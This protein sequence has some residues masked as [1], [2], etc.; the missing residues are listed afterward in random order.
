MEE[1]RIIPFENLG[2]FVKE[3]K[4]KGEKI[5]LT[6]GVWDLLHVGHIRYMQAAKDKGTVLIVGIDSDRLTKARKGE[7]RPIVP[8]GERIE[9]LQAL[10]CVDYVV[11]KDNLEDNVELVRIIMPDILIISETTEDGKLEEI[12]NDRGHYCGEIVCLKPQAQ[13]STTNRIREI[14]K[15]GSVDAFQ[16]LMK[17]LEQVFDK[18][19]IKFRGDGKE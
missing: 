17:D 2:K 8:E 18:H 5:V 13:T 3:L 1:T 12:K 19:G 14:V 7:H 15:T 16:V 10:R 11:L 4:D 9:M 6:L